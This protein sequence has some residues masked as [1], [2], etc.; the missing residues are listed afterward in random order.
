MF[1]KIKFLKTLILTFFVFVSF[2]SKTLVAASDFPLFSDRGLPLYEYLEGSFLTDELS[3]PNLNLTPQIEINGQHVSAGSRLILETGESFI[4]REV[5]GAGYH[6]IVLRDIENRAIRLTRHIDQR[7]L[8][9][10]AY[11]MEAALLL[12]S[13]VDP[14]YIVSLSSQQFQSHYVSVV[15][16][17]AVEFTL[18]NYL[19]EARDTSDIR[20]RELLEFFSAFHRVQSLGSEFIPVQ[21]G[22]VRNRGWVLMD[23]GPGVKLLKPNERSNRP[24]NLINH[25][26]MM[27]ESI[28]IDFDSI[29]RLE[30][31]LV[32]YERNGR[33][34]WHSLTLTCRQIF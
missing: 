1:K 28:G 22:Y 32:D 26:A 9:M 17:L 10:Q 14:R 18:D 24:L 12:S 15:E 11:Y 23:Y 31:D 2:L 20:Y 16:L 21:I 5:L 4:L 19:R 3:I 30:A 25:W 33:S 6:T 7:S 29:E 13:V 34:N 27:N 8:E